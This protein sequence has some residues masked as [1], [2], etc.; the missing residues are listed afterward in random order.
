MKNHFFQFIGVVFGRVPTVVIFRLKVII[1]GLLLSGSMA[2]QSFTASSNDNTKWELSLTDLPALD[3]GSEPNGD[4]FYWAF[5][6]FGNGEYYPKM[7]R[8]WPDGSVKHCWENYPFPGFGEKSYWSTSISYTYPGN[9]DDLNYAPVVI[10]IQ[11]KGDPPPPPDEKARAYL[12]VPLTGAITIPQSSVVSAARQATI[13]TPGKLISLAHSHGYLVF[14]KPTSEADAGE[15]SVFVI[16]YIPTQYMIDNGGEIRLYYGAKRKIDGNIVKSDHLQY[17]KSYNPKY[18]E[19]Q[20]NEPISSLITTTTSSPP[21]FSNYISFYL[22]HDFLQTV[23]EKIGSNVELRLFEE[24]QPKN[25]TSIPGDDPLDPNEWSWAVAVL[26]STEPVAPPNPPLSYLTGAIPDLT[27]SGNYYSI[28]GEKRGEEPKYIVDADSIFLKSGE[29]H[30][31]NRLFI[32]STCAAQSKLKMKLTFRNLP[33]ST[34]AAS[35]ANICFNI[36][37]PNFEWC[38][39]IEV[40][41]KGKN[42]VL[43]TLNWEYNNKL[44]KN[45]SNNNCSNKAITI[46]NLNLEIGGEATVLLELNRSSTSSINLFPYVRDH[47]ILEGLVSFI[48]TKEEILFTNELFDDPNGFQNNDCNQAPCDKN[49]CIKNPNNR[50]IIILALFIAIGFIFTF[51]HF[52]RKN[53]G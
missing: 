45:C 27:E 4:P 37:D 28:P 31:P 36:I 15:R 43:E 39:I 53:N 41:K 22:S 40:N 5:W 25:P 32:K 17:N 14:R 42:G 51:S 23:T 50:L 49:D 12:P 2:G 44:K 6:I 16:S 52:F 38:K 34:S 30:D 7:D 3:P 48:G 11:R 9:E 46:K 26:L 19:D 13:S 33:P 47:H 10:P 1:L 20:T 8:A 29:P 24:V 35:G 21:I 18:Y